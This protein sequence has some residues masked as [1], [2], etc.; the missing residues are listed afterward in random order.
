MY[1]YVCACLSV[2][3]H[4]SGVITM[5]AISEEDRRLWMEAMDGREPVGCHIYKKKKKAHMFVQEQMHPH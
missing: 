4:R 1:V 3:W 5:Q 2:R